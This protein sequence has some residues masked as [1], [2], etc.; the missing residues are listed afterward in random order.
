MPDSRPVMVISS[1]EPIW[2]E[3]F[4][5]SPGSREHLTVL[6][7]TPGEERAPGVWAGMATDSEEP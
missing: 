5:Q 6:I 4:P 7:L 1:L 2:I 3:S